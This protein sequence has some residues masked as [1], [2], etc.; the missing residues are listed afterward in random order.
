MFSGT[1]GCNKVGCELEGAMWVLEANIVFQS[2]DFQVRN[3]RCFKVLIKECD[4]K[5]LLL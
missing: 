3:F 5:L 4:G 1:G 2:N